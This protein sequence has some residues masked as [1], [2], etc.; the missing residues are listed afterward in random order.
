MNDE[1][2]GP[3]FDLGDR[4]VIA[5]RIVGQLLIEAWIHREPAVG[6]E[7][8]RIAVRCGLGCHF[9]ADD[10]GCGR[11]I[12]YD[13]RLSE[14]FVEFWTQQPRERIARTAGCERRDEADRP[15]G[16]SALPPARH[17]RSS[18]AAKR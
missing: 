9:E 14:A 4:L 10:P 16:C 8:H 2:L 12:V 5:S 17:T 18:S 11:P 6:A 3:R 1:D 13:D 7:E 15:H